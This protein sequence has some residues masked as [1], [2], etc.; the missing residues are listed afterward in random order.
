LFKFVAIRDSR[1]KQ[2]PDSGSTARKK[3]PFG[4]A[5]GRTI[6]FNES[7]GKVVKSDTWNDTILAG[8]REYLRDRPRK[9]AFDA[10]VR[11]AVDSPDY[12]VAPSWHGEI[13]D[14]RYFDA[15]LGEQPFAFIV[16]RAD[17]LFYVRSTGLRIVPGGLG[18]L[19]SQFA[20][21][22]E[23]SRGEWTVRITTKEDAERLNSFLFTEIVAAK[24]GGI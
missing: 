6:F 16:N 24:A 4:A 15:A 5:S 12:A 3:T 8:H 23:N 21:A 14:F 7:A 18:A 1:H 11:A 22:E 10:L 19:A 20:S 2:N 17:L 9:E 13:R